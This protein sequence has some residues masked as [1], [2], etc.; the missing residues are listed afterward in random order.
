MLS[1]DESVPL[2]K[3]G[4]PAAGQI[5]ISQA[6]NVITITAKDDMGNAIEECDKRITAD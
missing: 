6:G 4:V 2:W 5:G 1:L 3:N